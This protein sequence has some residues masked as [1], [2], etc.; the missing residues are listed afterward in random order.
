[1]YLTI[2]KI[3]ASYVS[4]A[5]K[6][7]FIKCTSLRFA[8]LRSI[9]EFLGSFYRTVY[10]VTIYH[11]IAMLAALV[12][13]IQ[14][15]NIVVRHIVVLGIA[16]SYIQ[17]CSLRQFLDSA[18][19]PWRSPENADV[20]RSE[21]ASCVGISPLGLEPRNGHSSEIVG[22]FPL[23]SVSEGMLNLVT[24]EKSGTVLAWDIQHGK[25][26]Y[27]FQSGGEVSHVTISPRCD[28]LAFSK[29]SSVE[30]HS[31]TKGDLIATPSAL[32]GGITSLEFNPAGD[33]LLIG[34]V[35]G[36]I[37]RWKWTLEGKGLDRDKVMERYVGH[38]AL[39][40]SI[41]YHPRGRFFFSGDWQGDLFAWISY[42]KDDPYGGYFDK[43]LFDKRYFIDNV[44]RMKGARD[45]N[46]VDILRVTPD[47]E[48]LLAANVTGAVEVWQIKGFSLAS[49]V[50][51]H[52]GVIFDMAV[53]PSGATVATSGRDGTV[54]LWTRKVRQ[55]GELIKEH[56]LVSI[57]SLSLPGVKKLGFVN[58]THLVIGRGDGKVLDI[59]LP[60]AS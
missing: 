25:A 50:P 2:C 48:I 19:E 37:Y 15:R 43:N 36:N 7:T 40:S 14:F 45:N 51:A 21:S 18:T 30:L 53:S 57:T 31:I 1:M 13:N 28:Q 12:R 39:P 26:F 29:G 58:D 23:G 42:D 46:S 54:K 20:G 22:V 52:Q 35:D 17:A 9:I 56:T 11:S 5:I 60:K 24:V 27:L 32:K 44:V 59:E 4:R 3:N 47:G 49:S 16:S 55:P 34:N 41:A 6:R 33:A 10:S 8:A 38:P